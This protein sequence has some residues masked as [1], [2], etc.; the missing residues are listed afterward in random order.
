M[1]NISGFVDYKTFLNAKTLLETAKKIE[2]ITN[3]VLEP[4]SLLCFEVLGRPKV[5]EQ[6]ANPTIALSCCVILKVPLKITPFSNASQNVS[7][8]SLKRTKIEK[9]L[10]EMSLSH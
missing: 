10:I 2:I 7:Q 6:V 3:I 9:N 4:D 8:Q 1:N 5:I